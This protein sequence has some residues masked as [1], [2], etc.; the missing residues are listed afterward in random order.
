MAVPQKKRNMPL[1][2][3]IAVAFVMLI[4]LILWIGV[5]SDESG[6]L[7]MPGTDAIVYVA[8]VVLVVGGLAYWDRRR[9]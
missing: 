2:R 7:T 3:W 1:S 6:H 4:G 5:L 9:S 8:A